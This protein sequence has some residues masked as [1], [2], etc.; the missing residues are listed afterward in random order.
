MLGVNRRM[1]EISSDN[2]RLNTS[3][4]LNLLQNRVINGV[5]PVSPASW[6]V[7]AAVVVGLFLVNI[8]VSFGCHNH[9]CSLLRYIIFTKDY[10][11]SNLS[12]LI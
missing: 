9:L 4:L 3:L 11:L 7:T 10:Y 8:D 1:A 6:F 5:Y 12:N 2:D